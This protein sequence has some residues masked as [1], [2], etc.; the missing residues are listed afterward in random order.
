MP[1]NQNTI[2][3]NF[4]NGFEVPPIIRQVPMAQI[5]NFNV[6]WVDSTSSS[7]GNYGTKLRPCATIA[8]ALALCTANKGDWIFVGSKHVETITA[9]GGLNINIAGVSIMGV[10][11]GD[12]RPTLTFSTAVTASMT[13]TAANVTVKGL[14]GVAGINALTNPIDIAT[15]SD[16]CTVEMHWRDPS[17]AVEAVRAFRATTVNRLKVFLRYE[18]R[19]AGSSCVN[20]IRLIGCNEVHIAADFYGKASTG[21]I[22]FLTTACTGVRVSGQMYNNSASLTKNVVDTA[23]G[24][25]WYGDFADMAAGKP[26]VGGSA[27][28]T[29]ASLTDAGFSYFSVLADFTSATW[30]TI[31]GHRIATVAGAAELIILPVTGAAVTGATAT[32]ALG[33]TTTSNSIIAA[34]TGTG[35]TAAGLWWVDTT[36]TRTILTKTLMNGNDIAVSGKNIGYTVATAALTGGNITFHVYWKPISLGALVTVGAGNAL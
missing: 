10:Q 32:L 12:D 27:T 15:G 4:A 8:T 16:G 21:W 35:F 29:L 7:T 33:D 5:A 26:L 24:S 2:A 13:I 25:T 1:L 19:T 18:G 31:A 3:A 9:A 14:V 20:A 22:E 30:N 23:T 34:T 6:Y 11:N 36:T 17:N 28:G